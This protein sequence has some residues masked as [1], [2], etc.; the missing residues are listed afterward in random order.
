MSLG[1]L[2]R[3]L[4]V[5]GLKKIKNVSNKA[6]KEMPRREVQGSGSWLGHHGIWNL[7]CFSYGIRTPR[8]VVIRILK[9]LD[10]VGTEE[11]RS[12]QLK[13]RRYKSGGSN[14]TRL[15]NGYNKSKPYGLPI[16]EFSKFFPNML[17]RDFSKLKMLWNTKNIRELS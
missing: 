5:Y 7:L 9:E 8:N 11:I 2:K 10:P 13:R 3:R 16:H 14:N 15:A 6:L 1:T 17:Q 12:R 4:Q